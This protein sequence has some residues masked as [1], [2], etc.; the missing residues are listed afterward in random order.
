VWN[1]EKKLFSTKEYAEIHIQRQFF[2]NKEGI[3]KIVVLARL[4][5][6]PSVVGLTLGLLLGGR[7]WFLGRS[8]PLVCFFFFLFSVLFGLR[9]RSCFG[10]VAS[11]LAGF[12]GVGC[13][14]VF[15]NEGF[16]HLCQKIK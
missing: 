8:W 14:L 3:S 4:G 11:P 2:D 16:F 9:A 6:R 12:G 5:S 13:T 10:L 1:I 7:V 15:C